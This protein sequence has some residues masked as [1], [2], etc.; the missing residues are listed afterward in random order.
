MNW[1]T[2][3]GILSTAALVTPVVVIIITRLFRYKFF[4]A[5]FVYCLMACIYN[6]MT[7]GYLVV[8]REVQRTF[9]VMT[10]LLDFPLMF[11]F[12]MIFANSKKQR[13]VM[14]IV[15][16]IGICF[17]LVVVAL[18]G[19]AIPSIIITMGPGIAIVFA[20]AL[21]FFAQN[22]KRS[23]IHAKAIGK[24]L[25]ASAVC[26]AYGCFTFLYVMY[27]ILKV[28]DSPQIFIVYFT[29]TIVYC[30]FLSIGLVK[31]SKRKR[32]LAELL[33]TRKELLRFFADE[34]KPATPAKD[35]TGQWRLN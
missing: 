11:T 6:L 9:G 24:A 30:S 14:T 21:Y 34:E 33:E 12:M 16:A 1:Q 18:K 32:K 28:P 35:I 20:Y 7:E 22:V 17:E 19:V 15:L 2:A 8:P 26:F 5:L 3:I 10:N 23:F 29:I 13:K 31:E 27:Y 25:M 4:L